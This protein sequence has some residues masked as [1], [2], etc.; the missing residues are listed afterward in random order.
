MSEK[1]LIQKNI[2][3]YFKE[4]GNKKIVILPFWD[5]AN[6]AREILKEEYGIQEQF[7]VDSYAYDMEHVYPADRMP[8]GY[9]ECTFFLTAF[10]SV[11]KILKNQLLKYVPADRIIDLLYD[12]EREQVFQ[13]NSKI[14][15]D[16]LCAGFA[17]C[18]TTSLHYALTQNSRIFLPKVKETS[19]LRYAVNEATHEAFK[20]HYGMEETKGKIVGGVEPSYKSCAE[21]VY[22]YFGRDLKIIF[23]VKNPA[24]MLYSYFKM[25]MRNDVSMFGSESVE[26]ILIEEFGSVCPEMFDK[27][28]MRY[29]EKGRYVNYIEEYLEFYPPDQIKI[30]ASE[31]LYTDARRLMDDLQGFLG[32]SEED[33]VQY[34]EFPQQNIG[35]KVVKDKQG[36]EINRALFQLRL[37]LT[38]TGDFQSLDL[39]QDISKKIENITMIDYK[40]PMLASTRQKLMDYYMEDICKLEEIMGRSLKDV[41]Y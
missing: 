2:R 35:S 7:L 26:S 40:E 8:E 36:L 9:E 30:I 38:H 32:L 29:R 18:G 21:E 5:F 16:F 10:G 34:R 39:F 28:A 27:W 41:W 11:K 19:F 14:H 12:E 17:K 25:A 4:S 23:C 1:E 3:N 6:T 13:S 24:D 20:N 22:H 37:S 31:E 33:R 15:L